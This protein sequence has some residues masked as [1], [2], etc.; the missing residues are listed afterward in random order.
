VCGR[1]TEEE[2][3]IKRKGSERE[4]I[5]GVANRKTKIIETCDN[6]KIKKPVDQ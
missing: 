5:N 3:L 2:E 4:K 1:R 6:G